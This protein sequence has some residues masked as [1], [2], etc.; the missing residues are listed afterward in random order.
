[1]S[2]ALIKYLQNKKILILGMG[3]EGRSTLDFLKRHIPDADIAVA[4]RNDPKIDGVKSYFGENYL[5][6]MKDYDLVMKSPGIPFCDVTVPENTEITC[7]TELFMRFAPCTKIGITGTKGKTTTSTLIFNVLQSAG[8]ES[9]LIGNIGVPVLS[10]FDECEGKTAVIELSCH[11]LEFMKT[12]PHI[13]VFTN[14]YEEHLD[15]YNGFSGYANA[16]LNITAHQTEKDFLI[17]GDVDGLR[18]YL[19]D[20]DIK[21]NKIPISLNEG[22]KSEFFKKISECNE[23]LVD[24][25]N[26]QNTFF[27]ATVA[28]CLGISEEAVEKGIMTFGGIEHRM[29]PVGVFD[30]INFVND[31]IATA[32]KV[33]MYAVEALKNVDTLI[34]GGMDRGLDYSEFIVDLQNSNVRNLIGLPQTG[35][36]ICD[37]MSGKTEK[38]LY[39][40]N[41]ME[42]AVK[43]AFSVTEKGK[44]CLFSPAAASYNVY[45]NFEEKG[46]HFKELIKKT[47]K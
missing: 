44:T 16:K 46:R 28:K 24:R 10:V 6:A 7:Q 2:E 37:A 20:K 13:A 43:I 41:D 42:D 5:D 15:H 35:H 3:R 1:M 39:K 38:S 34:F 45:K 32:P 47:A 36:S 19:S 27:A 21:A 22:E 18:E 29:E 8:V 9:C 11:Q 40:A 33:V 25:H 23:R 26:A 17:Y 12:S 4:D 14:L 30:G 31:S